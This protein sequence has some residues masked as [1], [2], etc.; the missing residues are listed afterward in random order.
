MKN[1]RASSPGPFIF[2]FSLF[3]LIG[4]C[5]HQADISNI[6][7]LCFDGEILPIFLNNCA[8][9]GCHDGT[10]ES[11][12]A[13]TSY[14]SIMHNI[15]P[16]NPAASEI[17]RSMTGSGENRMPPDQPLPAENRTKIR[18]WIEQGAKPTTCPAASGSKKSNLSDK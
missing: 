15:V 16:G 18:L 3:I 11:E 9:T 7:D 1:H 10:G 5:K 2:F 17:Y 13:Y 4:A 12:H 14:G 8:L 6:P